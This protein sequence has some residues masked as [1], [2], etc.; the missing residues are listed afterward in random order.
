M[1]KSTRKQLATS[2]AVTSRKRSNIRKPDKRA[3]Q[4]KTRSGTKQSSAIEILRSPAG[5][6]IESLTKVTG[7][8][9]HSVRGFL[10]GVVRKRLKLNLE[11]TLKEGVRIYRIMGGSAGTSPKP[12][13]ARTKS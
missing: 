1:V 2:R 8:Q 7:W 13:A 6:S 3:S 9:Q 11:S 10:A 5:A 12:R 4:Q